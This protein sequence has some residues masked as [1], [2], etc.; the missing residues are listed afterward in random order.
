MAIIIKVNNPIM[1]IPVHDTWRGYTVK[2]ELKI[3]T[4]NS[5]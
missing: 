1:P 4:S 2:V 3:Y 5:R